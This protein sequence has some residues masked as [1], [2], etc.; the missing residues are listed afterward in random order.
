MNTKESAE[1]RAIFNDLKEVESA[2]NILAKELGCENGWA[3]MIEKAKQMEIEC[4]E[5]R[6]R[7]KALEFAIEK[8]S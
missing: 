3:A 6:A 7:C 2:K 8:M 5:L 4:I 1:L